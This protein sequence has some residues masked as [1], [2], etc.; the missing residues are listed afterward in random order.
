MHNGRVPVLPR[1]TILPAM[2][3]KQQVYASPLDSWTKSCFG[4]IDPEPA[5]TFCTNFSG[6]DL[7]S[8]LLTILSYLATITPIINLVVI[9]TFI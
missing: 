4:V 9:V 1:A 6:P 2:T 3:V 8:L 7:V 5:N